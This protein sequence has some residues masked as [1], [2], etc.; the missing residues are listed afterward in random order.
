[1]GLQR[2]RRIAVLRPQL[3]RPRQVARRLGASLAI[4]TAG[5][6]EKAERA[7]AAGYEHVIDL[8]KESLKDGVLRITEGKGVDVIVD[9]V[10]GRLTGQALS[11]LAFGGTLDGFLIGAGI[12]HALTRN[13]TVKLEYNYI[14]FGS[15]QFTTTECSL[16]VCAPVGTNLLSANKQVFKVGV[17]YLFDVGH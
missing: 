6:A 11:S 12:E 3:G 1:M 4:S 8:S 10:S 2:G 14:G 13:W 7:R 16:G 5:N 15:K 9:G 17:N